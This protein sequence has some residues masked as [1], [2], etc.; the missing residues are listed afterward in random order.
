M[1][2]LRNGI[3][4]GLLGLAPSLLGSSLAQA[5]QVWLEQNGKG[6]KLY[7]GEYGENLRESSPGAL[8]KFA[9]PTAKLFTAKGEQPVTAA[10]SADGFVLAARAGKG[11]SIVAEDARYPILDRKDGD[12]TVRK[13]WTPAARYV[14]D[15]SV[16][17]A[18]LAL[19]VVPVGK[20]GELQVLFR[21]QPL[22]KAKVE[23][24]TPSGWGREGTTDE[25]GKVTFALPW[26]GA[27][28]VGVRH[29]EAKPGK[30]QGPNGDEA[31]D[32]ASFGTTLTF[33]TKAGLPAPPPAPP[34]APKK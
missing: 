8:D 19:D 6:A 3:A 2:F 24:V 31:Y 34:A 1:K 23:I 15:F 10:K 32:A 11:E 21:E 25:Q 9:G 22:P 12:K 20:P 27:Y 5:H 28:L 7:F 18:K 17:P 13:W 4:I 26:K 14:T 30:R 29:E 33:V 16:Q